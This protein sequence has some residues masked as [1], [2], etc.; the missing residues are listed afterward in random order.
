MKHRNCSIAC[1]A[2]TC[3]L[4]AGCGSRLTADRFDKVK[5]GMT[6]SQVKRILGKPTGI[7]RGTDDGKFVGWESGDAVI[8]I[9][10]DKDGK[11][12]A[13]DQANLP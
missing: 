4:V 11:L 7:V 10:F 12:F 3:L 13:K 1:V 8:T 2:L 5:T 6:L 9:I